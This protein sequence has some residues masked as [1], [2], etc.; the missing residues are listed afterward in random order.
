MQ[1]YRGMDIG[2]SKASATDRAA[3]PHHLLDVV[4]VRESFDAAQF[5]RR[6]TDAVQEIHRRG[7]V[8]IFCGGTGLYFQAYLQ[9]LGEAPPSAPGVR[10]QLRELPL[11]DLLRELQ[12]R[13]PE[14]F[15]AIDRSNPRR[16]IRA[17]EVIRLTGKKFSEQRAQWSSS[18]QSS[19]EQAG[20]T[21]S[22]FIVLTRAHDD[23]RHRI[24]NRVRAMFSQGLVAEVE[25]LLQQGFRENET[26]LQAIGY[27]QVVDYLD[28]N[29]SLE[30]TETLIVRKTANYA[31]RQM[32]WFR[33][34]A[35]VEWVQVGATEP[36]SE[37][38][39]RLRQRYLRLG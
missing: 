23:L 8:P 26:A 31:K 27:R 29:K 2:T 30:E 20:A 28:G 3:I 5:V 32:T 25:T 4:E 6:A 24:E 15:Q 36:L 34:Y 16:V 18:L 1:V 33:R 9:G 38:S 10:S 12:L 39:E 19:E 11:P 35:D 22:L 17:L 13:D 37:I 7:R 21:K 14:A